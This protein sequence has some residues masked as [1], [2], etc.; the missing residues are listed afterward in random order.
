MSVVDREGEEFRE[1]EIF[2]GGSDFGGFREEAFF[3]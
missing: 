1:G 2:I 3:G